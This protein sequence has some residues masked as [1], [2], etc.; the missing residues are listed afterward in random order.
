[1]FR[2]PFIF[3]PVPSSQEGID[4]WIRANNIKIVLISL[5]LTMMIIGLAR[6]SDMEP[7]QI[8]E[9]AFT[10][11]AVY[12]LMHL[13]SIRFRQALARD[14][15]PEAAVVAWMMRDPRRLTALDLAAYWVSF[16]VVA[17]SLIAHG[18]ATGVSTP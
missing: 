6:R 2:A 12:G 4:A 15:R 9:M 3:S 11:A 10:I 14:P 18:V 1:M 16:A 5:T 8:R 13:W 17:P 7:A